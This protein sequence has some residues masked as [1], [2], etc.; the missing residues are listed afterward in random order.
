LQYP[1][2]AA[3]ALEQVYAD[4]V[5]ALFNELPPETVAPVLVLMLPHIAA[6]CLGKME[7]AA[8]IK[9]LSELP[10]TRAA[11]IYRLLAPQIQEELSVHLSEKTRKRIR[12]FLT[13]ASL[14]A[15]DLM[16]PTVN[17]LPG[18]LTVSDAIRR[19]K[20]RSQSPDCEIYVIDDAHHML[21][22]IGLGRLLT[23]GEHARL[24]DI[25]TRKLRPITARASAESLITHPGWATS[26]RLPVIERDKTLIGVLDFARVKEATGEGDIRTFDP[27]ESMLSLVGL[28]WLSLSQ[29][30]DSVLSMAG[31]SKGE[32]R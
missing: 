18:N 21:G 4:D 13:Y 6:T 9:L 17:M 3:R 25:M 29:L 24:R 31:S 28:Y 7:I 26:K 16:D 15:G 27:M 2:E 8:A 1:L 20:R 23:S 11:R 30:L 5:A 32:S 12:R 22:V 19:L 10:V 14:T